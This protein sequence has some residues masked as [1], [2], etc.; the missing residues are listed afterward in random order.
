[1]RG[2]RGDDAE[3]VAVGWVCEEELVCAV[4]DGHALFIDL[5]VDS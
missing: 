4:E 2:G 5:S 3:D 1:M